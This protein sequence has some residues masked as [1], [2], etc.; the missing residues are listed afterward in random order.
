MVLL[1]PQ[2]FSTI[3]VDHAALLNCECV[4]TYCMLV[5]MIHYSCFHSET[6]TT[7]GTQRGLTHKQVKR[8]LTCSVSAWWCCGWWLPPCRWW[9]QHTAWVP[10][11]SEGCRHAE[12]WRASQNSGSHRGVHLGVHSQGAGRYRAPAG[13]PLAR[14]S[15]QGCMRRAGRCSQTGIHSASGWLWERDEQRVMNC[16]GRITMKSV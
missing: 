2:Q 3:K 12:V 8:A 10:A 9:L 16:T 14:S 6:N 7:R 4:Y 15:H 11:V 1:S 5:K 13:L